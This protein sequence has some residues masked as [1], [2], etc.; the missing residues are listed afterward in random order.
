MTRPPA[1]GALAAWAAPSPGPDDGDR[2]S[3]AP[4]V[5]PTP[6]RA[7]S[8]DDVH[9]AVAAALLLMSAVPHRDGAGTIGIAIA[10]GDPEAAR[11]EADAL[12]SHAPPGSVLLTPAAVEAIG[13]RLPD[14]LALRAESVTTEDGRLTAFALR[15]ATEVVPHALPIP[16]TRL[17]GRASELRELRDLLAAHRLVTLAGPPG[18]GKTRL[19]VELGRLA[20][21]TFAD[22]AWFVPLAPIQDDGLVGHAVARA[23]D[24]SEK[25]GTPMSEVVAQHLGP[26]R[27][28]L[29]LDNFEHLLS[30]AS[31]V[32]EW[33]AVAPELHVVVTSREPL[34][35]SGEWEFEVPPLRV[36]NDAT[37]PRAAEAEA[38]QL[39]T[40]RARAVDATFETDGPTLRDVVQICRRLDGL[41]LAVEL[42]AARAK[43]LPVA[44]ILGRL[45]RSLELLTRGARDIPERHH[46]LRAAVSWSH[47]LL[48][49]AEQVFFRRL[50]AFRGGWSLDAADAVTTAHEL[51]QD[52]LDLTTSLLDKSLI[53]RHS[54][55]GGEPRYDMLE[56]IREFADEQLKATDEDGQTMERHAIWFLD[57][58]ER[59]APKLTGVERGRWLDQLEGELDNLRTA[60]RWALDH[61]RIEL[62]MRL[63]AALWR[64]WQIRAHMSEGRQVLAE[65]LEADAEVDPQIR[66]RALSAAGSLAYWQND[67]L[68]C[69]QLYEASLELRRQQGDPA[70]VASSLYDLGHA[71]SCVAAVKDTVRGRTLLIESLE[72]YQSLGSPMGEAWLLWALGCN[73]HFAGDNQAAID[74][75][76]LALDR[77]RGLDDPF[78]LAWA[79]TM[80]GAAAQV[81]GQ[82]ELATGHFR[83]A[84]PIFAEVDDVSGLDSV[85]EH[86]ARAAAAGG[87]ARRAVLLA[88]AAARIRG[89]SESAIMLMVHA[90]QPG[91]VRP[92]WHDRE[93][94]PL[95]PE[96]VERLTR[97]GEAM[98]TAEAVAY[99]LAEEGPPVVAG[100]RIRALGPM[101][102]ERG[103]QQLQRW[104]G[105]K[106]GS[107]QAQAIFAFLFDRGPAGISK[108]EAVEL[109]WPDLA[110]KRG[111]LAFHR[112]LG[113]LRAM[114]EEGRQSG[115]VISYEG[116]RYRLAPSLVEWSDVA[117]FERLLDEAAGLQGRGRIAVLEEA[118]DLYRGAF[119]DDC[120]FYGDSVFVEERRE[121]LRTRHENLLVELGD[122]YA[123]QGEAALAMARFRE[124]LTLD[125]ESARARSGMARLGAV[126]E[127]DSV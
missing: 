16:T 18:S 75:I 126:A 68:P 117:A 81:A 34:H 78:G 105:D 33:L 53:R 83:E 23:L 4:T 76:G 73:R 21:G 57:L 14:G 107:R 60:L 122:R 51:G 67:G 77:F 85:I 20:L 109:L 2:G 31:V 101:H 26:R 63:A 74:E 71:I 1:V 47:D 102:V 110:I 82:H 100:L 121:Y 48:T 92:L 80:R 125:P 65:L 70:E 5:K 28:L 111:D 29:I 95:T 49:P 19:A 27:L 52:A 64:F 115:N 35:L 120:P 104:G 12:A 25:P 124:A 116:G 22:G 3:A 84:L 96:E 119:L 56:V 62:G 113:G 17:I 59:A 127:V 43:A 93:K 69:M 94:L 32:A 54:D 88:A 98:T 103:G 123:A 91:G 106:A 8:F 42:A 13:H 66:A 24:L 97:E 58:A 55:P 79:L 11:A 38:V 89:I 39:F 41:P 86:L 90:S 46:S 9:G 61:R 114:L 36:P 112:T 118:R 7:A 6:F 108:D 87:D 30:G 37:D 10:L 40:E 72:L 50:A 99:A 15:S 44:S 45:E